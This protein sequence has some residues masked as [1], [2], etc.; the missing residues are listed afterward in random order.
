MDGL[1]DA[2][3]LASLLSTLIIFQGGMVWDI[4]KSGA[5]SAVLEKVSIVLVLSVCVLGVAAQLDAYNKS[6]GDADGYSFHALHR[7]KLKTIVK[8]CRN[9]GVR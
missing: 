7:K 6:A 8:L 1:V 5:L 3:E 4:D 9:V 2:T